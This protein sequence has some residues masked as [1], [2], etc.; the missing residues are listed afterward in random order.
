M[1]KTTPSNETKVQVSLMLL[2]EEAAKVEKL[3]QKLNIRKNPQL[4]YQ[5]IAR[6][7]ATTFNEP[8]V[9]EKNL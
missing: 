5:A 6:W 2:P 1:A 3:K 8:F 4:V 9:S 7:Y